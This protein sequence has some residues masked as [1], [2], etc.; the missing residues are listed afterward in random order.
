MRDLLRHHYVVCVLLILAFS[1]VTRVWNLHNPENYV[2]DE[3]YH[4]VTVKLI[5]Q[6]DARA[7]EWWNAAPEPNTAVDWLHPPL[8]K[9]TQAAAVRIAGENS[10]GWRISSVLFGVGVIF[11]VILLTEKL[12]KSKIIALTAGSIAALDGL[13]LVQSRIAMNDIHVSFFIILSML[14][15]ILYRQKKS[16]LYLVL[17]AVAAGLAVASK[18]SGLFIVGWL[19][20]IEGIFSLLEITSAKKIL[21]SSLKYLGFSLLLLGITTLLYFGS[22]TQMFLQGKSLDHFVNLHKQIWR[23]QTTLDATHPY[24]SRPLE[25]FFDTKPVW[26]YVEY[27]DQSSRADIYAFGN[28]VLQWTGVIAVVFFVTFLAAVFWKNLVNKK[29]IRT[30]LNSIIASP[31]FLILTAYA[32]VWTPWFFSPRIMFYY[33]YTP[34]VPFLSILIAIFFWRLWSTKVFYTQIIVI[35]LAV[36]IGAVFIIWYPHWTGIA[37]PYFLKDTIYFVFE[38]WK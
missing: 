4:A 31:E 29:S 23:Y 24:Q 30:Q 36:L 33:H 28:P 9:L 8:A 21:K 15:Y 5:A 11:M 38:G 19:L 14:F 35:T 3:V 22:Y 6:D 13:L 34:A 10:F 16:V 2:F 26:Y 17:T 27:V 12:T 20:A 18:W 37:V 7:Y 25:W 32:F 1:F